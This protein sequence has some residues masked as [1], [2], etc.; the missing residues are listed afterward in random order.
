MFPTDLSA[1]KCVNQEENDRTVQSL[2]W[3]W[4]FWSFGVTDEK[5]SRELPKS[6]CCL[7]FPLL[8]T[9]NCPAPKTQTSYCI[10]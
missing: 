5:S 4:K 10:S 3:I 9:K 8:D 2:E 1:I 7:S 6:S